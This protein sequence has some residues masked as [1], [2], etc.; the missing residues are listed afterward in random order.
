MELGIITY[1]II[2]NGILVGYEI[3]GKGL[4]M[5]LRDQSENKYTDSR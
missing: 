3:I 5:C 1:I 4:M 2:E